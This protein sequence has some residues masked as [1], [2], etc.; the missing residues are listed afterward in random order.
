MGADV[1]INLRVVDEQGCPV[2]HAQVLYSLSRKIEQYDYFDGKADKNGC[3]LVEGFTRQ[4]LNYGARHD[5]YYGSGY[6]VDCINSSTKEDAYNSDVQKTV[7][8]KRIESKADLVVYDPQ[9]ND[10]KI[11]ALDK[12][13]PLDLEMFDWVAPIGRGKHE[14]VLL[15]FSYAKGN[16]SVWDYSAK[17]ELS[18]TNNPYAGA[19]VKAKD[20]WSELKSDKKADTNANFKSMIEFG[21]VIRP[22][23]KDNRCWL[24]EDSYLIYRTRTKVDEEGKLVSAHYGKIYGLWSSGKSNVRL[25]LGCFNPRENDPDIEDDRQVHEILKKYNTRF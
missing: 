2:P 10:V 16:A 3:F 22:D 21:E 11:P 6:R 15:R 8:L 17:M 4:F 14:D 18:F 1:K 7:I 25:P 24:G 13:L 12:W 19:Y 23:G 5:G 9:R 20:D